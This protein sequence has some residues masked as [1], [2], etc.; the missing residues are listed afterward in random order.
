MTY[1]ANIPNC[2]ED[3]EEINCL[4]EEEGFGKNLKS[5]YK[6]RRRIERKEVLI[7]IR[8]GKCE[9]CGYNK[10]AAALEFHHPNQKD[11]LIAP[12]LSNFSDKQFNTI[13]IPEVKKNTIL[14]CANCHREEHN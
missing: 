10:K 7:A 12:A 3:E 6:V 2:Y 8:G 4:L 13:L 11:F 14:L 5:S 1:I 9:N